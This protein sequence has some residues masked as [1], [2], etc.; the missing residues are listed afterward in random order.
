MYFW[1]TIIWYVRVAR[2]PRKSYIRQGFFVA[3]IF[4][5][6]DFDKLNLGKSFFSNTL[7][8]CRLKAEKIGNCT[9]RILEF[10]AKQLE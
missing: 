9:L 4:Y 10:N 6:S 7:L 5:A 8:S 1:C 3:N 2:F